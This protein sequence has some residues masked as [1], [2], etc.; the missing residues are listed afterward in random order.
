MKAASFHSNVE[1]VLKNTWLYAGNRAVAAISREVRYM[2]NPSET[3]RRAPQK[4]CSR[5]I[6]SG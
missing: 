4:F 6:E 5:K 3:L 2:S 1:M